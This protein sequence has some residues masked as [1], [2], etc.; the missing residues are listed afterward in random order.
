FVF[1]NFVLAVEAVLL[2]TFV[3][4]SQNRQNRAAAMRSE[5]EL[6]INLLAEQE[7][8]KALQMLRSICDHLGLRAAAKDPELQQL[9]QTTHVETLAKEL[10]KARME[11]EA[12]AAAGSAPAGG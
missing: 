6:Q 1:L 2:G 12:K 3:L 9:S 7:S 4:M 10:E 5:L 8:T 11:E